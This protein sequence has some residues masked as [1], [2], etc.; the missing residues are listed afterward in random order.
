MIVAKSISFDAAH[1]LPGYNGK[2]SQLHGHNWKIEFGVEGEVNK[3]TGM[4][5]DFKDLKSFLSFIEDK[6]DHTLLNDTITNPTAEN[7]C[8]FIKDEFIGDDWG[9]GP[10][11]L[12][13]IKV[14]ETPDSVAVLE[15]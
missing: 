6:L 10:S 15:I 7:L 9:L 5:V 14:W 11:R 8:N 4:V 3:K 12:K 1:F 13:W 2:C